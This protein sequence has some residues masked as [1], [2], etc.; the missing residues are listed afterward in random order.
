MRRRHQQAFLIENRHR[1]IVPFRSIL[2][3]GHD[4]RLGTHDSAEQRSDQHGGDEPEMGKGE[5]PSMLKTH[6]D[7]KVLQELALYLS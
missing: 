7:M 3:L 1:D 5:R 6:D 4:L 2:G